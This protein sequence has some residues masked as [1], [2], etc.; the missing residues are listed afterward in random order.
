MNDKKAFLPTDYENKYQIKTRA[1]RPKSIISTAHRV[2]TEY[3]VTNNIYDDSENTEYHNTQ[4]NFK[5]T[6]NIFSYKPIDSL[7]NLITYQYA[8]KFREQV[9][10]IN[11]I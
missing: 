3:V 8:P 6:A 5:K 11:Y 10:N 4:T 7:S 9:M 1:K 2:F